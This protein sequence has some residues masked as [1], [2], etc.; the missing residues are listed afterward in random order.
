MLR[1]AG[2]QD[3]MLLQIFSKTGRVADLTLAAIVFSIS[4]ESVQHLEIETCEIAKYSMH[5]KKNQQKIC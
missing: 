3:A 4:L 5:K 1:S 2:N